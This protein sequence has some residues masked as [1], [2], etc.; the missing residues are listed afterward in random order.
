[1]A[2]RLYVRRCRRFFAR[3]RPTLL[4]VFTPDTGAMLMIRA[5]HDLGIPVL[6]HEMGTPHY[7]PAVDVYYRELARVLPLCD[8]VAALSQL[9]ARQ[10]A[11]HFPFI[12]SVSVLPLLMDD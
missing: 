12:G 11:E 3:H 1:M 10:W 2:S 8:E 7:M 4:H 6:Y 5:G 9:L